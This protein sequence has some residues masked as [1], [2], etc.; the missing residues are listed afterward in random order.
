MHVKGVGSWP[1]FN[2]LT[3][4][5]DG[6]ATKLRIPDEAEDLIITCS[7]VHLEDLDVD[8]G[9]ILL[10]WIFKKGGGGAWNGLLWF[11]M[12]TGGGRLCMR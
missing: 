11:P 2:W 6:K 4:E 5:T 1:G 3:T 10:K 8:G 7:T 9:G 12:G